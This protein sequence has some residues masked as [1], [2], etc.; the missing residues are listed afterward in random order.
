MHLKILLLYPE[1]LLFYLVQA[2]SFKYNDNP[3][4]THFIK[5]RKIM[6]AAR[7]PV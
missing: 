2:A 1:W 6:F 3:Q 7:E 4:G 5:K